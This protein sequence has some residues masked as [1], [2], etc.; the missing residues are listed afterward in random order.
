MKKLLIIIFATLLFVLVSCGSNS[1]KPAEEVAAAN[2]NVY[3]AI[4]NIKFSFHNFEEMSNLYEYCIKQEPYN[5]SYIEYD[6]IDGEI[7][8]RETYKISFLN[9]IDGNWNGIRFISDCQYYDQKLGNDSLSSS[10]Y[11]FGDPC[12]MSILCISYL[13]TGSI[14]DTLVFEH[15]K[16]AEA[17]D[18]TN[19]V[20]VYFEEKPIITMWYITQLDIPKQEI[21]NII[22]RGIR[23][24]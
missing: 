9:I 12:S 3:S 20:N 1:I 5:C 13:Y 21:E 16:I 24:L 17:W 8:I 18:Y 22:T 2:P 7:S 23:E 14:S 15:K 6:Q 11:N 10:K 4:Q 19:E